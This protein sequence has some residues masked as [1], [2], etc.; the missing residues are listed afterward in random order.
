MSHVGKLYNLAAGRI[1]ASLVEELEGVLEAECRLVIR[2]G[3][4]VDDPSL[5]DLRL[6]C[7]GG[8][9]PTSFEPEAREIVY[10]C[11]G[12]IEARARALALGSPLG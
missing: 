6:R 2:I 1:A 11:L 4:P 8:V 7:A 12:E 3:H 5:A 10:R 9:R